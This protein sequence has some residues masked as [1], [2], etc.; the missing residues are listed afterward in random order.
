MRHIFDYFEHKKECR[1][2][3]GITNSRDGNKINKLTTFQKS[4]INRP[5]SRRNL[6]LVPPIIRFLNPNISLPHK[7]WKNVNGFT[8]MIKMNPVYLPTALLQW[9]DYPTWRGGYVHLSSLRSECPALVDSEKPSYKERPLGS[10]HGVTMFDWTI[11]RKSH[12]PKQKKRAPKFNE[13]MRRF[14]VA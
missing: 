4:R 11:L 1:W 12:S 7:Y 13:V 9:G 6:Q 2:K 14:A 5:Q 10:V 3:G 8:L